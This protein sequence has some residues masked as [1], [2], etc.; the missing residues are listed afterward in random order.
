MSSGQH[1]HI[2][3]ALSP[4]GPSTNASI[5]IA[6]TM[7]NLMNPVPK[8]MSIAA[9]ESPQPVRKVP[10]PLDTMR[11]Y[12]ACLNC[13]SRKS[14]CDLDSNGGRP[15]S[16]YSKFSL[17]VLISILGRSPFSSTYL[18]AYGEFYIVSYGCPS[19][20]LKW[21][22]R[23]TMLHSSNYNDISGICI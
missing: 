15:V 7:G 16:D 17:C 11:A 9:H 13:R 21:S 8:D 4:H 1:H 5:T 14:K 10:P 18:L 2:T 3:P 12:R 20:S 6:P 23:Y 19:K 22:A